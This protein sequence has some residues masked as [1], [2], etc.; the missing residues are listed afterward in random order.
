MTSAAESC[1]RPARRF[2]WHPFEVAL[3]GFSGS[4]KTTLA[5]RLLEHWGD[6]FAVGYMKHDAHRFEMDREGKDTH[7]AAQAGAA[8]V[9]INDPRH[10]A[11]VSTLPLSLFERTGAFL[12]VDFVLAEG[13]KHSDLPKLLLLDAEGRGWTALREG[14]FPEVLALVGPDEAPPDEAPLL[15]PLPYFQRDRVAEIAAF[16]EGV[17]GRASEAP[18]HG[19]VL[20][21]GES[22][23][24]G[25][26]KY[27]LEYAGEPQAL[28]TARLL[29]G[30]CD[31][32]F[33]SA[34]PG[35]EVAG[36]EA[37]P[38]IDDLF[39]PW[40]PTSGI[41]SAMEAHPGAA[42]LV[43]ACDLPFL[44][45]PTARRLASA[46]DRLRVATAFRSAHGGLPE[47]L[48]AIW[49]PRARQRI[50]Q[51]VGAGRGCPRK[52]LL[53]SRPRLLELEN[54]RA[55]DNANT[56]DDFRA[57]QVALNETGDR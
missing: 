23:R 27:A 35:Q 47:P 40:G 28:R 25:T 9:M 18:L 19:L 54:P 22:R 45:E 4:G 46:R 20:V 33:V 8:V 26:P 29:E 37:H 12:D 57:A 43:A 6:R 21:G 15:R 48:F 50:L 42:W 2:T 10:F 41:L 39:P 49:E 51:A 11:R 3:S 52:I 32:V 17:V 24:M 13:F 1:D 44:D 36:L 55:L 56:P 16:I 31:R 53:E 5:C 38:R 14:R 34:R 30:V 7:R